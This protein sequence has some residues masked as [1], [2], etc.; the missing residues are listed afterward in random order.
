MTNKN[1]PWR[2]RLSTFIVAFN[3]AIFYQCIIITESLCLY[4]VKVFPASHYVL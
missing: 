2:R 4:L 3:S 1:L